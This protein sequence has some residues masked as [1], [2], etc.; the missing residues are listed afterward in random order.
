MRSQKHIT[1]YERAWCKERNAMGFIAHRVAGSGQ[2][3]GAVCD[4]ISVE[5]KQLYF[6]ELKSTQ[7]GKLSLTPKEISNIQLLIETARKNPPVIPRL[8][9][10]WKRRG[11][12]N[13]I[14]DK[15]PN[16]P[17]IYNKEDL[18]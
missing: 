15:M 4:T 13:I 12:Q 2:M 7:E 6:N 14:L 5:N 8:V 3:Q 1:D 16:F 17:V 11:Y 10:K 9:I 18:E